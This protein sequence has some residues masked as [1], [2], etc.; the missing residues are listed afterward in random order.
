M[1]KRSGE[2]F[3]GG[4]R[5]FSL[6]RVTTTTSHLPDTASIVDTKG[7]LQRGEVCKTCCLLP[8]EHQ[9]A[10]PSAGDRPGRR[11]KSRQWKG[12]RG[13]NNSNGRP[14]SGGP[15]GQ[16]EWIIRRVT[17]RPLQGQNGPTA[18]PGEL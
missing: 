2:H 1:G 12:E 8:L 15:P 4:A 3:D 16:L 5:S 18:S 11:P 10:V 6:A 7:D 13:R 9:E 17:T 14:Q